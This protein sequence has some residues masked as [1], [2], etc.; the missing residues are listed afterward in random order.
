MSTVVQNRE[1]FHSICLN[2]NL[3][4]YSVHSSRYSVCRVCVCACWAACVRLW[5]VSRPWL[6][7]LWSCHQTH[8]VSILAMSVSITTTGRLLDFHYFLTT[9]SLEIMVKRCSQV[10]MLDGFLL[11]WWNGEHLTTKQKNV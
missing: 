4:N 10:A 5:D 8:L 2:F 9:N 11:S 6:Q 1:W 3:G 7:S